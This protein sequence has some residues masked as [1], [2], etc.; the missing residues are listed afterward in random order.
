MRPDE[1]VL[2]LELIF[3]LETHKGLFSLATESES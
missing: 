3:I 1:L 2:L